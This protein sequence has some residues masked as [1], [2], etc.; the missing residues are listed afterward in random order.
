VL[1]GIYRGRY[2]VKDEE[3]TT[4]PKFGPESLVVTA[5]IEKE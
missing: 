3:K 4:R 1:K 5:K 2:I